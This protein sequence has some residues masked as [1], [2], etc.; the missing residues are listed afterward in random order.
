MDFCGGPL[1]DGTALE[2]ILPLEKVLG[3]R[4]ENVK[5]HSSATGKSILCDL[6][7][8]AALQG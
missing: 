1:W 6:V 8:E 3:Y 4:G 5:S 7:I 2:D